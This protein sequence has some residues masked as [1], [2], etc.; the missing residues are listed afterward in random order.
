MDTIPEYDRKLAET[1]TSLSLE[2][3]LQTPE[4]PKKGSRRLV[5]SGCLFV[6]VAASIL[7]ATLDWPDRLG[8]FETVLHRQTELWDGS[9]VPNIEETTVSPAKQA[10]AQDEDPAAIRETP[11]AALQ[12]VTGSGYVVAPSTTAVFSKYEGRVVGV[13]V[14]VGDHVEAGQVVVTLDDAGARFALEQ[15]QAAKVSAALVLD[16]RDI[17]FSQ[18]DAS[19]QRIKALAA[20]NIVSKQ[21]LEDAQADWESARNAAAQARQDLAKAELAVRIA[22]EPVNE[23]TVRAP[24]DGTVTQLNA[25]VG[26]TVLARAD[27]VRENQSLLTI[28]DT[29]SMVIDADIAEKNIAALRPGLRGEAVLDAFPDRP[30]EV[31]V[32]RLAPVASMEKGTIGLRLSLM[33]A[34][35]GIRPNMAARI[36]IRINEP[37]EALR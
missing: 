22:Q 2:P 10:A 28:T 12:E 8:R 6:L 5:L 14:D 34:P 1:L 19:L 33:A 9:S 18:T 4:P 26:D 17:E 24:F 36:R 25:H 20:S 35:D 27:S 37:G 30:F 7:A 3:S 23:L 11:I 29:E 13:A 16:A 15:A 32:S 21:N 31:Q